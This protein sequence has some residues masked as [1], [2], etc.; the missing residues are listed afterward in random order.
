M[1]LPR[2]RLTA[3][4]LFVLIASWSLLG[5]ASPK[6]LIVAAHP[7]DELA[8]AGSVYRLAKERGLTVDHL[9]IT[10]GE[11]GYRYSTLAERFYGLELTKEEVG[12]RELPDIRKRELMGAGRVLGIRAHFFLD[13]PD[14]NNTA[15][16]KDV[17]GVWHAEL[18]LTRLAAI[19]EREKY[20]VLLTVLPRAEIGGH[21]VAA[22]RLALQAVKRAAAEHRPTVLGVHWLA[23]PF[24]AAPG[25]DDAGFAGRPDYDFDRGRK[26]GFN[27]A[28]DYQIVANWVIAEHKSQGLY[29]TNV[30]KFTHEYFW[31]FN[32]TEPA[33]SARAKE[34]F[35][36]LEP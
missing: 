9:V 24:S 23:D 2:L 19:L 20:D 12:R 31:I 13:E 29:Q 15:D 1:A 25:T 5:A 14:R 34:L 8:L 32:R 18:V 3:T 27:S 17:I 16:P 22:S 6:I 35:A 4:V 26:F 11:G 7:D 33:A 28:L 30:N 21:H 36:L 10:N